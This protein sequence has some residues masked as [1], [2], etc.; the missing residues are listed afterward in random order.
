MKMTQQEIAAFLDTLR[1]KLEAAESVTVRFQQGHERYSVGGATQS[2]KA[3]G[4]SI[5]IEIG[6]GAIGDDI[7]ESTMKF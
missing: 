6:S 7:R 1:L 5:V 4:E 2:R 3:G